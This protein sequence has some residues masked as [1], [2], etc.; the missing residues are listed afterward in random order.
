MPRLLLFLFLFPLCAYAQDAWFFIRT[1]HET[2]E[3]D[4]EEKEGQLVYKGENKVLAKTLSDYKITSFKKTYKNAAGKYLKRTYFVIA[5]SGMLLEDLLQKHPD[6][7]E[8]GEGIHEEDKKIFEPIN[9]GLTSTIGDNQGLSLNLDYLDFLEVPKAWY[10][11]TGSPDVIIGIAD[12]E[13]NVENP[14]FSGKAVRLNTSSKSAG[15]GYNIAG[16]AASKGDVPYGYPGVCYNCSIIGTDYFDLKNLNN[17]MELSE[18]GAKVI[19]ASFGMK[20]Y[21]ETAQEMINEIYNNGTI[22]V[23][24]SH[25]PSWEDNHGQDY[26]YPASY[27]N[28]ISVSGVMHRYNEPLDNLQYEKSGSPYSHNVKYY[29]GASLGFI[30]RDITKEVKIYPISI[31]TMNTKV[32]ILAPSVGLFLYGPYVLE[33]K[34]EYTRYNN[35]SGST[36][37]V[38]G[39]VGLMFSLNPCLP[40]TQVESILKLTSTNIDH[41]KANEP[42]KGHYGAGAM[43]SGKA[44]KAVYTLYNE[45]EKTI[46][47]NQFF[48]RWDFELT[49]YSQELVFKDI[50]FVKDANLELEAKYSIVLKPGVHLKPNA[51]AEISLQI[52]PDLE[53]PCELQLRD[54]S[55]LD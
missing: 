55:I 45:K 33:D 16:L 41:I 49:G 20:H 30:D 12:G 35:T 36:A 32:D 2:V 38:S 10:Y 31:A 42:Y 11:T 27:D 3:I 6:L 23:A 19:N 18:K 5:D 28:V 34:L 1:T 22:I 25:N 40:H 24:A 7:F 46:F 8:S 26:Y 44:V 21:Y 52:N 29:I 9:Y 48:E 4:F 15:H 37:L 50:S 51:S 39:T 43:N 14:A 54:P 17:L 53:I 13:F 47:E